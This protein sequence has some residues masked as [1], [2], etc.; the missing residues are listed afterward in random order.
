M[1]SYGMLLDFHRYTENS[2]ENSF[3]CEVLEATQH[4]LLQT[5]GRL[6]LRMK[7][8]QKAETKKPARNPEASFGDNNDKEDNE[9]VE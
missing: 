7:S 8:D 3:D 4:I 2:P 1:D 9:V 6:A 5:H